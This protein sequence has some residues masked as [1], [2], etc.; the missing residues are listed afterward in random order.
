MK[1]PQTYKAER[2]G[3]KEFLFKENVVFRQSSLLL[4]C[5]L[6][7]HYLNTKILFIKNLRSRLILFPLDQVHEIK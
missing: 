5:L 4:V 2:R 1:I 6:I 3:R 7:F